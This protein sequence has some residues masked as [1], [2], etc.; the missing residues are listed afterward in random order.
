MDGST[1]VLKC[2]EAMALVGFGKMEVNLP[3]GMKGKEKKLARSIL[4]G[5]WD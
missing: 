1:V 2:Q 4:A 3:K 5:K